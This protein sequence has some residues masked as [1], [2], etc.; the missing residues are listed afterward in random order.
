MVERIVRQRLVGVLA[1]SVL[2][3]PAPASAAYAVGMAEAGVTL[4]DRLASLP[5]DKQRVAEPVER[6]ANHKTAIVACEADLR[7]HP[8]HPRRLLQLG[9]LVDHHLQPLRLIK[10]FGEC[11]IEFA[12]FG[13]RLLIGAECHAIGGTRG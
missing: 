12:I 11:L 2:A 1:A 9:T 13:L 8:G 10:T 3:A 6:V 5:L 4:C 7:G